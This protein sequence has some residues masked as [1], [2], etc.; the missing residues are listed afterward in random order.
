MEGTGIMMDVAGKSKSPDLET[1]KKEEGK[2]IRRSS[3]FRSSLES[4]I[5]I[6]S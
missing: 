3:S 5:P 2:A 4:F 1:N 6:S